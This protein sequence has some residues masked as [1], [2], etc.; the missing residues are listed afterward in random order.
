MPSVQNIIQRMLIR[1]REDHG[2]H[3]Y[4]TWEKNVQIH[5]YGEDKESDLIKLKH[6]I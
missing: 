3:G 6:Y 5:C 1:A 4:S 2:T